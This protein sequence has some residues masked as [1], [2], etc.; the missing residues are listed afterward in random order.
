MFSI[1]SATF[2]YTI[3]VTATAD[4]CLLTVYPFIAAHRNDHQIVCEQEKLLRGP[5]QEANSGINY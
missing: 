2:R 3:P 5:Q 1:Y 4:N